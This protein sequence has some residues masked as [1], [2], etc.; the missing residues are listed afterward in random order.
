M[1]KINYEGKLFVPELNTENGEVDDHTLFEDHQEGRILY[2]DYYG[3][4]VI[5][6]HLIGTVFDDNS[7]DFVYHHLNNQNQLRV[8]TCHSIPVMLES[9]KLELH[10]TWQWLNGDGSKG[11]SILREK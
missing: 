10:E 9:G 4:D 8:G 11:S 6:G 1:I 2:A 3:G 7:M 5:K